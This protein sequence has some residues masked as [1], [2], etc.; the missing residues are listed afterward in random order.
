[1]IKLYKK[2]NT[3]LLHIHRSILPIFEKTMSDYYD[4]KSLFKHS[5]DTGNVFKH[6]FYNIRVI[7]KKITQRHDSN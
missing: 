7:Q 2:Q 5:F 3:P 1:M 4:I 6:K